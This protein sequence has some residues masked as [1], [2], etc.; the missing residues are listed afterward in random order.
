[1]FSYLIFWGRHQKKSL[2]GVNRLI[3][4]NCLHNKDHCQKNWIGT[5][6]SIFLK[7]IFSILILKECLSRG[8]KY[9]FWKKHVTCYPWGH[10]LLTGG[11]P[12]PRRPPREFTSNSK[13]VSFLKT[14]V[15][16]TPTQHTVSP[17]RTPSLRHLWHKYGE[18]IRSDYWRSVL[19]PMGSIWPF[20]WKNSGSFFCCF[21]KSW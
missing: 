20:L 4:D 1:M 2:K 7:F 10:D 6:N 19:L 11:K 5:Q 3:T 16:P 14:Q 21:N 15:S 13:S 18:N 9:R 8:L 17:K 12:W